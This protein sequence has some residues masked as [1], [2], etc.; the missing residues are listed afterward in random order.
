MALRPASHTASGGV[1]NPA[2]AYDGNIGDILTNALVGVRVDDETIPTWG[3]LHL[4]WAGSEPVT[5]WTIHISGEVM[6]MPASGWDSE[7]GGWKEHHGYAICEYSLDGGATWVTVWQHDF[8]A[9][10][11]PALPASISVPNPPAGSTV[12]GL[13]LRFSASG[14]T[15]RDM[16]IM[17]WKNYGAKWTLVDIYATPTIPQPPPPGSSGKKVLRLRIL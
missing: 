14:G 11:P 1:V 7:W 8:S 10:N 9:P 2:G 6:D 4:A 3:T 12:G 16:D 15:F 17:E 13:R 5:A